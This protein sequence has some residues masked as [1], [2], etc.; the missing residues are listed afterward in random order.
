VRRVDWREIEIKPHHIVVAHTSKPDYEMAR[1]ILLKLDYDRYVV[2]E[3]YHCSC[4]DFDDTEWE[5]IEYTGDELRKL[6]NSGYNKD[7][8]FWQKVGIQI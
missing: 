6:A 1:Q 5:A 4:Y 8:E 2:L 7:S 3:G